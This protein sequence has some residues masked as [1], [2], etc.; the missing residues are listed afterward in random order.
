MRNWI[1][2]RD[3]K[4]QTGGTLFLIGPLDPV[5]AIPEIVGAP[6]FHT[7]FIRVRVIM[8]NMNMDDVARVAEM[9]RKLTSLQVPF[10]SFSAGRDLPYPEFSGDADE[11]MREVEANNKGLL[12]RH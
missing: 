7:V 4:P 1:D 12:R 10:V 9:A 11:L 6:S 3:V 2:P 5:S 8:G